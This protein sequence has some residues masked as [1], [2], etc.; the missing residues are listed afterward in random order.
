MCGASDAQ[1]E[2]TA[3]NAKQTC[4]RQET[5]V[6]DR[7]PGQTPCSNRP[8]IIKVV[9]YPNEKNREAARVAVV[10]GD[11]A[12]LI[13]RSNRPTGNRPNI[14]HCGILQARILPTKNEYCYDNQA[15]NYED[16]RDNQGTLLRTECGISKGVSEAPGSENNSS[17]SERAVC[18]VGTASTGTG[19]SSGNSSFS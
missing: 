2:R 4:A 11:S 1:D 18:E 8:L 13:I 17:S 16:G 14:D 19:R 9:I 5:S 12:I 7:C 15:A 3:A 6:S 10:F